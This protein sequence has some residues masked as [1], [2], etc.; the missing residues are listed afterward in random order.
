MAMQE[1][2]LG[3]G[4]GVETVKQPAQA[5][6]PCLRRG[7]DMWDAM[8]DTLLLCQHKCRQDGTSQQHAIVR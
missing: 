8:R 3:L 1:L 5:G 2:R 4:D 7:R 6:N